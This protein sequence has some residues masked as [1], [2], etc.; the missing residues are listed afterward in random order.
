MIKGLSQDD[1]VFITEDGQIFPRDESDRA[2]EMERMGETVG[3]HPPAASSD[4]LPSRGA[5]Y[6]QEEVEEGFVKVRLPP[7]E[8]TEAERLRHESTHIPY[9]AWCPQ[10]VRGRGRCKPHFRKTGERDENAVPKL[11]M[12]YFFLGSETMQAD[13]HPMFVLADE[14][15]GH[16]YA[17]LVDKKGL[18]EDGDMDWLVLDACKEIRSWGHV[19]GQPLILKCDGEG[20]IQNVR[21]AMGRYLGGSVTPENPPVGDK[22]ANGAAE[23][24]GKTVRELMK[25]YKVQRR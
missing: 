18:N 3:E 10:C 21:D 16:R 20:A 25:V 5:P 1:D 24:A 4:A 8:P 11:T 7:K 22:A 19:E 12:D 14:E 2:A 17:R 6:M 13:E 15:N 23:E 9:R